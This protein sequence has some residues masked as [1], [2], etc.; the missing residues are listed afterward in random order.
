MK[1]IA[2]LPNRVLK[3]RFPTYNKTKQ[4]VTRYST[5]QDMRVYD[6]RIPEGV[7]Q[8]IM[9]KRTTNVGSEYYLKCMDTIHIKFVS[10][11]NC[12]KFLPVNLRQ[13]LV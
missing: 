5:E 1:T 8:Q 4:S 10:T 9:N 3:Q 6:T 2:R 7:D 12:M 13:D 11:T